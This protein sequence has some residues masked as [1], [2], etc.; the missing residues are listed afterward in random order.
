[1]EN[2][3]AGMNVAHL[4]SLSTVAHLKYELPRKK[5]RSLFNDGGAHNGILA[6]IAT[7]HLY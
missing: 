6:T 1:M 4:K 3:H 2:N 5:V 7:I